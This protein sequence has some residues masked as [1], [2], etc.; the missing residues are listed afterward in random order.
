[1]LK[2]IFTYNKRS[3]GGGGH[4]QEK[5]YILFDD[6]VSAEDVTKKIIEYKEND[7]SGYH[8]CITLIDVVRV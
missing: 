8:T 3:P 1:M 7:H 6:N 4:H 5:D 2:A